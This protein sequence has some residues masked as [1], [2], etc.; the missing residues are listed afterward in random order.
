MPIIRLDLGQVCVR[1][2]CRR[3]PHNMSNK[4]MHWAVR[5]AWNQGWKEEVRVAWVCARPRDFT[6]APQFA[7]I[8]VRL[9]VVRLF[10][11]D[12]AYSATKP[13]LD[14]LTEAGAIM[15]DSPRFIDLLV[16]QQKVAHKDEEGVTMEVIWGKEL[17]NDLGVW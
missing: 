15:D 17:D 7:K 1:N 9:C 16:K 8:R 3:V 4:R 11:H 5:N 2:A 14:G 6:T 13:L 12:G 10:D